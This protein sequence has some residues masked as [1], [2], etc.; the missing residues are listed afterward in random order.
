MAYGQFPE[1][2]LVKSIDTSETVELGQFQPTANGEIAHIRAHMFKHGTIGGSESVT[3]SIHTSSD[4]TTAYATSDAVTFATIQNSSNLNT[5][6]DWIGWFRFDFNR[7]NLNK[8]QTY[9]V[10]CTLTNYT[11]NSDTYYAG[12]V[13][14]FP[15][16]TYDPASSIT[17]YTLA[18][19][20]MKWFAYQE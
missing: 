15:Y 4:L 9:Y 17:N 12:L 1:T 20:G 19:L 2:L 11:R 3:I 10:S 7:E 13:Y 6:G 8:N 18:P 16:P 5:T 14:D